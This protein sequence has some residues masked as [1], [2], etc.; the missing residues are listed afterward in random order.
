[1]QDPL[2]ENRRPRSIQGRTGT[3]RRP[4]GLV[5]SSFGQSRGEVKQRA[6]ALVTS[7]GHNSAHSG[8]HGA[9]R[10]LASQGDH[11]CGRASVLASRGALQAKPP[12]GCPRAARALHINMT[13]PGTHMSNPSTGLKNR[14]YRDHVISAERQGEGY[15]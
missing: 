12:P 3:A 5:G 1:V 7:V 13:P 11:L 6:D 15:Q 9:L 8:P 2:A 10:Q 4:A 14:A